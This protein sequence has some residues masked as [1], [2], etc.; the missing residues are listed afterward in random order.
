MD[1]ELRNHVTELVDTGN[2]RATIRAGVE[3]VLQE[4]EARIAEQQRM[5]DLV[6]EAM[7]V[8]SPPKVED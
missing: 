2:A 7:L 3:M 8:E 6:R 1:A 4:F 5:I